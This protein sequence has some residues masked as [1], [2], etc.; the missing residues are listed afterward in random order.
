MRGN[1]VAMHMPPGL[2]FTT[3]RFL[4]RIRDE[5]LRAIAI[6]EALAGVPLQVLRVRY[7]K[8]KTRT[9]IEV[10]EDEVAALL[11]EMGALFRRMAQIWT[12]LKELGH[13]GLRKVAAR[14]PRSPCRTNPTFGKLKGT[15]DTKARIQANV[16]NSNLRFGGQRS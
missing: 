6:A 5:R 16:K 11:N 8:S 12:R 15:Q 9:K 7:G 3:M 2:N 13:E 1:D 10:P 14:T 4:M